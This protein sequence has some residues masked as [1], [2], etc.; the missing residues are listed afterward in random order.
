MANKRASSE[1][2]AS[3]SQPAPQVEKGQPVVNE[4]EQDHP[5]NLQDST[6]KYGSS[7][8]FTSEKEMNKSSQQD[9]NITQQ[10]QMNER[11]REDIE[12]DSEDVD[13]GLNKMP[14]MN[15]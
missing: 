4:Q 9:E 3:Q 10:Q 5:V 11:D 6:Y 7:E 8:D 15:P 14:K 13:S 1:N 2:K 12:A